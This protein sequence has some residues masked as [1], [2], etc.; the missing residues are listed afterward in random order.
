VVKFQTED[1]LLVPPA[2]EASTRQKYL[3]FSKR[4]PTEVDVEDP[5]VWSL[6]VEAK[7]ESVESWNRYPAAVGTLFQLN[8][9]A[10]GW[11]KELS[12]GADNVGVVGADGIVVKL[13]TSDHELVNVRKSPLTLQ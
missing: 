4:L 7:V 9:I 3:V 10:V 13:H 1:Q 12:L 5:R 8:V 11:F 6:N 2:F